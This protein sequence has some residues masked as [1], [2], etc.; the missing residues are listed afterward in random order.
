MS[1]SRDRVFRVLS[2][3]KVLFDAPRVRRVGVGG[4]V[5]DAPDGCETYLFFKFLWLSGW[6]A[7]DVLRLKVRDFDFGACRVRR[8]E[9]PAYFVWELR[10]FVRK[11]GRLSKLEAKVFNLSMRTFRNR[12]VCC[13][14]DRVEGQSLHCFR[15]AYVDFV[16]AYCKSFRIS[17]KRK[18]RVQDLLSGVQ[19]EELYAK[20]L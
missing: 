5:S 12:L 13:N 6:K 19:L 20:M 16:T 4:F 8:L 2:C 3:S 18:M 9:F 11:K 7:R 1:W 15:L 14:K 10:E 17:F